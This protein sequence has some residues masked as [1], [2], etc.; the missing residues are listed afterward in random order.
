M[1]KVWNPRQIRWAQWL[2]NCNFKIVYGPGSRS[3]KPEALSRRPEYHPEG[4]ATHREQSILKQEYFELSV[5][6]RKDR[7]QISLVG[8]ELPAS[9]QLRIQRL[10]KDAKIPKKGS[11]MVAGHDIHAIEEGSIPANRQAL[12]GTG[13]SIELPRGTYGRLAARSEMASNNGI[14]V[15]GGVIDADYTGEVKVILRNHGK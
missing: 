13:I 6:Y 12:V 1:T 14:A 3:E 11:R 9:N 15:G 10:S 5:C 4:G 8:K 2:A 7:I